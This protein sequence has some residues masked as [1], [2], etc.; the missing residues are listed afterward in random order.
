MWKLKSTKREK[1]PRYEVRVAMTREEVRA[2]VAEALK[3]DVVGLD[4]ETTSVDPRTQSPV[5]IGKCFAVQIGWGSTAYFIP[6][7]KI[8]GVCDFSHLLEELIPL[9]EDDTPRLVLHNAKFDA[10]ILENEGLY[11][12]PKAFLGDTLIASYTENNGHQSHGLKECIRRNFGQDTAEF[13]ETF[14]VPKLKKDGKPGK[15]LR[16]PD[17]I[18]VALAD[19]AKFY[20]ERIQAFRKKL[21]GQAKGAQRLVDAAPGLN[22][23]GME[24]IIAY[25]S[26]DPVYT[27]QL[28][29]KLKTM[30]QAKK[31]SGE[32]NLF[33]YFEL[34]EVPYTMALYAVEKRGAPVSRERLLVAK[35]KCQQ[36]IQ[37]TLTEFNRLAV[38]AG[39]PVARMKEFNT[40]SGKDVGWLFQEVLGVKPQQKRRA[41]GVTSDS[42]DRESIEKI[43][44]KKAQPLVECLLKFRKATKILGT[45]IDPFLE[46]HEIYGGYVHTTYKQAGTA[47]GRLSSSN[48]NLQNIMKSGKGDP[49][50]IRGCFVASETDDTI[51][52]GDIDL[53]QVE[54]RITAHLTQDD[55]LLKVIRMGWDMHSLTAINLYPHIK[56]FVGARSVTKELLDEIKEKF[57]E[58]RSK[59]KIVFFAILYGQG[60]MGY[61]AQT[62]STEQQGRD[63]IENFFTGYPGIRQAMRKTVAYAKQHGYI[64]TYLRRYVHVPAINSNVTKIR[65][66]GER[67]AFNYCIQASCADM[68]KCSMVKIEQ[69]ARL[70][71]LKVEMRL[72]VH[73]E[74]IFTMPKR[75]FKKAKPIIEY[76]VSHPFEA[77]GFKPL[78]VDTP[79]ELD[80]GKSWREAK[81]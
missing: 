70:K 1:K 19:Q 49:Y 11:F 34:I 31:W 50:D 16:L 75:S 68:L 18:E 9:V 8:E 20:E 4:T 32:R 14:K 72:Q 69:D 38:K 57:P 74:L 12:N 67:Q 48:P 44:D 78:S 52:M 24:L 25:S 39:A 60:P 51:T 73:D 37:D 62:K 56:Q 55:L 41:N 27:E 64:R 47:T 61:A 66:E 79:G 40:A 6:T 46:F 42:W 13:G 26:L 80:Q 81:K 58:E 45:Y 22:R 15:A 54:A 77:F 76:Y 2:C 36:D 63:A 30:M 33:D 7:F 3:Q 5:K 28:Y 35:E 21:S 17:L 23:A 71:E 53:A 29:R 59:A 43:K 10:A 65:M